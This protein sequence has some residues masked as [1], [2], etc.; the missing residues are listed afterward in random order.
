VRVTD[1]PGRP[2]ADLPP[3]L[4]PRPVP[5]KR[6]TTRGR[7]WVRAA[8]TPGN[9]ASP[10]VTK[11]IV[12]IAIGVALIGALVMVVQRTGIPLL[13]E[14]QVIRP[15]RNADDP[16]EA[17]QW[18]EFATRHFGEEIYDVVDDRDLEPEPQWRRALEATA[19]LDDEFISKSVRFSLSQHFDEVMKDPAAFRGQFVRMRGVV[20]KNFRAY[21]LVPPIAG[22]GDFYRG[23]ISD[24]DP[25]S[26]VVFFDLLDRP[27]D[28]DKE[29]YE[30]VDMDAAFYRMVEYESQ[31]ERGQKKGKIRRAPW[32]IAKTF[33]V[34]KAP[35]HPTVSTAVGLG[36]IVAFLALFFA[37][38]YLL[39][40]GPARKTAHV[41]EAG[42][43]SMFEQRRRQPP[44]TE[45]EEPPG[46]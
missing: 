5:R 11:V 26:P 7:D 21:K 12:R 28:F 30:A 25:D 39:R 1:E 43:R 29:G 23:Q 22:R 41:P 36:V 4:P 15:A 8:R 35:P 38:V 31:P 3:D 44:L 24:D 10:V 13:T 34:I 14:P 42:F 20:W 9:A 46:L 19:G 6:S 37:I 27:A 33:R 18:R 32:L 17:A 2:P 40:R 16:G 45:G